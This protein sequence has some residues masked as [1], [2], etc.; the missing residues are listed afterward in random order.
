MGADEEKK[1]G[2]GVASTTTD[3]KTVYDPYQESKWT[4]R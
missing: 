1:Y 2:D 3:I 4:R